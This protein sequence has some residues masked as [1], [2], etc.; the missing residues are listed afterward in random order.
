MLTHTI[1]EGSLVMIL[2]G[3][4]LEVERI[5]DDAWHATDRVIDSSG[6]RQSHCQR[7]TLVVLLAAPK[8]DDIVR[9]E[10]FRVDTPIRRV[11]VI[12]VVSA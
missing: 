9:V 5:L 3:D 1:Q 2:L 6:R 11:C 10:V 7:R 12:D 4:A 8:S